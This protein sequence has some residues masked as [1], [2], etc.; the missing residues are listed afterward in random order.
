MTLDAKHKKLAHWLLVAIICTIAGPAFADESR[1]RLVIPALS[2]AMIAYNR[3]RYV[4]MFVAMAY[5]A[6]HQAY[7]S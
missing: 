7:L 4:L 3:F 2:P 6:L 5:A 1:S